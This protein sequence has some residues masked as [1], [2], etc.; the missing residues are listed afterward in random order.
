MTTLEAFTRHPTVKTAVRDAQT[1]SKGKHISDIVDGNGFQ[2]VDFVM[3]G[4]GVLG[5]ALTGYTYV[6]EQAGIRFLGIGGT[7]AGS[8][9]ALMIAAL[10][11]P[12]EA[13]SER[14]LKILAGMPMASFIDGD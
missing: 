6:L 5:I 8:I 4:G 2:Y 14:L 1:A 12:E 11:P 7:S 3:E 10:G 9:N 13:K